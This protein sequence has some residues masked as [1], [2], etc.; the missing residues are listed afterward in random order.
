MKKSKFFPRV[1]A[2]V[3]E[4]ELF[5]IGILKKHLVENAV[6]SFCMRGSL[7]LYKTVYCIGIAKHYFLLCDQSLHFTEFYNI[8]SK[9]FFH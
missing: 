9:I 3:V 8:T 6:C 1:F 7:P 2:K 4:N 5:E